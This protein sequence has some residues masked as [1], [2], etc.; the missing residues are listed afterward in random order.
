MCKKYTHLTLD[1]RCLIAGLKSIK[2][3]IRN[4]AKGLNVSPSTVS[5]ELKRNGKNNVYTASKAE[6]RSRKRR[7]NCLK[8]RVLTSEIRAKIIYGLSQ[9]HS[10]EQIS[11]SLKKQGI[12]VSHETIYK[13]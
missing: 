8:P 13:Y 5:R 12:K 1:A 6:K 2:T 11:G 3:S 4:I 10:P 9:Y 7:K